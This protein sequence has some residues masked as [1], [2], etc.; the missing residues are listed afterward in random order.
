MLMNASVRECLVS[1]YEHLESGIELPDPDDRHVVAAALHSGASEIVTFNSRDFPASV[2][3]QH[4]LAVRG[5]D[6]FLVELFDL[7]PHR[8]TDALAA[9]RLALKFPPKTGAEF[10]QI[11]ARQGLRQLAERIQAS[12]LRL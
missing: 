7:E 2:L 6:E 1:G 9:Q 12:G 8:L 4:D 5:P 10:L 3:D 11:L